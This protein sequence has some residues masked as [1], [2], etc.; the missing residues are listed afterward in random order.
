MCYDAPYFPQISVGCG[1]CTGNC[2][3][4]NNVMANGPDN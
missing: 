3:K 4:D 2:Q 1:Y